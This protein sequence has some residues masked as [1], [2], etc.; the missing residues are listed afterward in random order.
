MMVRAG[1]LRAHTH[2]VEHKA[3]VIREIQRRRDEA[4][5][6]EEDR[7]AR[8]EQASIDKLLDDA[9]ALRMATD[10]RTYVEAVRF[11]NRDSPEPVSAEQMAEWVGWALLQA[12]RIDPVRSRAFL[13]PIEDPGEPNANSKSRST[14]R[15]EDEAQLQ[16]PWHPNQKWYTR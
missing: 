10:I 7:Q 3:Y 8:I 15:S 12:E 11:A 1:M 4:I 16:R 6:K 9:A 5:R 2:R 14:S 13:D